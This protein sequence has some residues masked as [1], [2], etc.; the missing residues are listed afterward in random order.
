[1]N[2]SPDMR[3]ISTQPTSTP[4]TGA[5]EP[6]QQTQSSNLHNS[7][8]LRE[9]ADQHA[10]TQ[11][12]RYRS[13]AEFNQ[14]ISGCLPNLQSL[15][16]SMSVDIYAVMAMAQKTAQE[17]RDANRELRASSLNAQVS[18][19]LSAADDMDKAAKFRLAAGIVQ[20]AMKAAA[21]AATFGFNATAKGDGKGSDKV[22]EI[23]R[24]EHSAKGDGISLG[25]QGLGDIAAA[26]LNY[27]ASKA[28][29]EVKRHEAIAKLHESAQAEA[30]DMMQQMMD[31]IR[32]VRDK[33][34]AIDQSRIETNRGIS[35]NI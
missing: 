28:D 29:A 11:S 16:S 27:G 2:I 4:L 19:L 9:A 7:A 25:M 26:G 17:M 10:Q 12:V 23:D 30:N 34:S 18:E 3:A 21:G 31:V 22:S 14:D 8:E 32:D 1:M 35:R 33:V 6:L 5:T 24:K 15:Q 20:G 13:S